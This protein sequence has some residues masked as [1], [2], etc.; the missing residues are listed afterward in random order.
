MPRWP[1]ATPMSAAFTVSDPDNVE[2]EF[3]IIVRSDL[4]RQGLGALLFAQLIEHAASATQSG[5][6]ALCCART[7]AC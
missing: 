4:K 1:I 7:P 6:W 2:A 5:W 3:A